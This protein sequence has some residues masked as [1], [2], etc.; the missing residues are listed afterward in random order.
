MPR[1][2]ARFFEREGTWITVFE[3]DPPTGRYELHPVGDRIEQ[4][5][6]IHSPVRGRS[7]V[8]P[9]RDIFERDFSE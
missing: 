5:C 8:K 9:A 3:A 7:K 4:L 2:D 6:R 1:H